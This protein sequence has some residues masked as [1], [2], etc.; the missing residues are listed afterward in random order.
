ME[1]AGAAAASGGT[2]AKAAAIQ[3]CA[4]AAELYAVASGTAE[5]PPPPPASLAGLAGAVAAGAAGLLCER[6]LRQLCVLNTAK[7]ASEAPDTGNCGW[8]A[9]C[10]GGSSHASR[11]SFMCAWRVC[12]VQSMALSLCI[13]HVSSPGPPDAVVLCRFPL[14]WLS[15]QHKSYRLPS[16]L[17]P[18]LFP[19]VPHPFFTKFCRPHSP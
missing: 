11:A 16:V 18:Q 2:T 5:R 15:D 7:S 14:M 1:S 3:A 12:L 9:P 6:Q 8:G 10:T 17:D 13:L 4:S 19:F